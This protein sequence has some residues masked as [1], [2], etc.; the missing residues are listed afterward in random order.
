MARDKSMPGR[1]DLGNA[2]LIKR[3]FGRSMAF[4]PKMKRWLE[5]GGVHWRIISEQ[6]AMSLAITAI[7]SRRNL[8]KGL[9]PDEAE[10]HYKWIT[11]SQSAASIR[12]ALTVAASLL[13]YEGE[14][15]QDDY[16][17]AC[18]NGVMDLRT[19]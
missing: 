13:S 10:K 3:S 14:W 8:L 2:E 11:K 1:T 16:L 19:G 6:R 7:K 4:D 15:D 12:A 17:F 18:A 9:E 5:F